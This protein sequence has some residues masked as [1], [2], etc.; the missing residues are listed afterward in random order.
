MTIP[1]ET[2]DRIRLSTDIVELVREYVPGLKKS[3]R[4]WKANCPF[5]NEKTPSFMVNADKGIFHCFGCHAGGDAFKFVMQMDSLNWPEAV[6]KL[7]ER[8]GIAVIETK[9]DIA[10]RSEKQ[11]LYD[12]LEQAAAFYHRVLKES[13][14]A[15]ASRKY[16]AKRGVTE[17]SVN[18]FKLGFA[19]QGQLVAKALKKGFTEQQLISAGLVTRTERGKLFEYMSERIVFPIFD[20]QGRV[21]AFG[22][23]ALRDEQPKYLNSPES[24]VYSKSFQ[25]Y[26]LFEALPALRKRKDVM[27]LEGYMDVVVTHQFGV[28]NTVATL[29][30]SLTQQQSQIL[31]RYAEQIILLFDSD[32]A[33]E[34]AA[35]RAID[36]LLDTE[37]AISVSAMP[38]AVDPD[39]YLLEHGEA[40]FRELLKASSVPAEEYIVAQALKVYGDKTPDSKVKAAA[41]VIPFLEKIK[42]AVLRSE[43][44]KY[45]SERL[46]ITEEAFLSEWN[47]RKKPSAPKGAAQPNKEMRT[48]SVRTAEAEIIQLISAN[49]ELAQ[50]VKGEVFKDERNK[51]VFGLLAQG[52]APGKIIEGLSEGDANWLTELILEE[53][54]Y[55][56]PSRTLENIL[57]DIRR[58][59]L[60]TQRK[61][62]ESEINKMMSGEIPMDEQKRQKYNDLN[63]RLKGSVKN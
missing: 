41:E 62:L 31:K 5:H 43:W 30:T 2:I 25:L 26:G 49:P 39:E 21:V 4:N 53:K 1:S 47:R 40:K 45:V 34:K 23:R 46:G 37:L 18:K 52:V 20:T 9:E 51:N 19:P 7:G 63:E 60:E 28:N 27:V 33:G 12:V 42:N 17:E 59:E 55:A 35:K 38:E 54:T 56:T 8:A 16:F 15:E 48:D 22:G 24:A 10:K 44:I 36:T 3:G 6:R 58:Q 61:K 29:G 14:A 32:S 50:Q 13:P 11:E 57:N